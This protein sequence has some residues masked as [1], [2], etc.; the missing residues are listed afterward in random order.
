MKLSSEERERLIEQ[1]ASGPGRLRAAVAAV[2]SEAMKWR[3]AEGEFS[4]HEV[5]CHC[6]DSETVAAA[7]IRYLTAEKEPVIQGYDQDKWPSVHDY[8]S[9]PLEAALACV[10]AVRANTAPLLR[11]L[12]DDAWD[13]AGR[14]SEISEP[15]TGHL[16]LEI[17]SRHVDEHV[18]QIERVVE[19]WRAQR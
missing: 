1:Y 4:V 16:W 6:A 11:R 19:A 17:D 7:R 8:H 12:P 13:R 10:E 5:V 3:P 9:H 14:H 15:Y 2:P 18:E